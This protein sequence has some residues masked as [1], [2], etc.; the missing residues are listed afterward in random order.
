MPKKYRTV[1]RRLLYHLLFRLFGANNAMRR[2]L[3]LVHIVI[4]ESSKNVICV[5][6][7]FVLTAVAGCQ[8]RILSIQEGI[9]SS[10]F[11]EFT[12]NGQSGDLLPV[13]VKIGPQR[14]NLYPVKAKG[15][16]NF[17]FQL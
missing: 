2:P 16:Y 10:R 4:E 7:T 1:T 12:R 11:V 8:V 5:Y 14:R 3:F 13:A 6:P 9:S 15:L 17:I